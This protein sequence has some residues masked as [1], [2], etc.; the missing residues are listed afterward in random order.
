LINFAPSFALIPCRFVW[1][2]DVQ[3]A[4]KIEDDHPGRFP[5]L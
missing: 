3:R 1:A 2:P 4:A 5:G